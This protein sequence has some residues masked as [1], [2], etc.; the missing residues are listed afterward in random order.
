[1]RLRNAAWMILASILHPAPPAHLPNDSLT[2]WIWLVAI[3]AV[4]VIGGI[5]LTLRR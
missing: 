4:A 2:F 1:M 5:A 3:V